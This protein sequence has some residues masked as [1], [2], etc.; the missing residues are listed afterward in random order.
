MTKEFK[1][2]KLA[3][4]VTDFAA[5]SVDSESGVVLIAYLVIREHSVAVF[6]GV[7]LIVDTTVVPLLVSEVVEL[8]AEFSDELVFFAASNSDAWC[9]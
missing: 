3:T 7:N 1:F 9:M 8:L 4:L 5:L 2:L 6:K